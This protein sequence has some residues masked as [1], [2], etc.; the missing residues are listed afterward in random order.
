MNEPTSVGQLMDP[1]PYNHRPS[2]PITREEARAQGLKSF[3][4][5]H[6]CRRS[7]KHGNVRLTSS[8]RCQACAEAERD[9]TKQLRSQVMDRLKAEAMR[10]VQKQAQ[11]I[12]EDARREATDIIKSAQREA[13]DKAKMLEKAKATREAK[14]AAKVAAEKA[15]HTGVVSAAPAV[16]QA[17]QG[18]P[19]DQPWDVPAVDPQEDLQEP[20]CGLD[21]APWD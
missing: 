6:P 1:L 13:N 14:K 5:W 19:E 15:A 2:L 16:I 8:N 17:A 7:S 9:L 18:H 20:L 10:K 4:S 3:P 21:A 12:L 11:A